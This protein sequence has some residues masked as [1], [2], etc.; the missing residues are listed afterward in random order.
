MNTLQLHEHEYAV[1][2]V[3]ESG[4]A[5]LDEAEGYGAASSIGA[6]SVVITRIWQAFRQGRSFSL[7]CK[8]GSTCQPNT[9]DELAEWCETHFPACYAEHLRRKKP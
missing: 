2:T 3:T 8:D 6:G 4:Y 5:A 7:H 9:E 1:G